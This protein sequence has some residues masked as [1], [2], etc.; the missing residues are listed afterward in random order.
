MHIDHG[1]SLFAGHQK[2]LMGTQ[3]GEADNAMLVWGKNADAK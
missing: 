3:N 1:Q 2:S